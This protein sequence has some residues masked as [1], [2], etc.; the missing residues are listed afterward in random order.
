VWARDAGRSPAGAG[1][2][3]GLDGGPVVD[4]ADAGDVVEAQALDQHAGG[5][6]ANP[7]K[8][9]YLLRRQC[10]ATVYL[11][12]YACHASMVSGLRFRGKFDPAA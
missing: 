1:L 4:D 2:Q 8:I 5:V 11:D 12:L 7:G 3:H 6:R 10:L 9:S